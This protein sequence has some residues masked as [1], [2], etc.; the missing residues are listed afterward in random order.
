MVSV[1][2]F[3][4]QL[5]KKYKVKWSLLVEIKTYKNVLLCACTAVQLFPRV[6][7]TLRHDTSLRQDLVTSVGG[8]LS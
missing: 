3:R 1:F 6:V 5:G 8:Q 2:G 7:Q 4:V